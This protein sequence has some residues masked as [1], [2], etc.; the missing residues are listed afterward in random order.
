MIFKAARFSLAALAALFIV[1]APALAQ[2]QVPDHAVPIGRGAGTGFKSAVPGAAGGVLTSTGPIT[3]P[4]FS[5]AI[6]V[7]PELYGAIC[8]GNDANA[9]INTTALANMATAVRA[10][11]GGTVNFGINKVCSVMPSPAVGQST[12]MDFQS[13]C[14]G[15]RVNFNGSQLKFPATFTGGRTVI[16]IYLRNCYDVEINGFYAEQTTT[17]SSPDFNNGVMGIVVDDTNRDIRINGFYQKYG[18]STFEC[19]RNSELSVPNRTRGVVISSMTADQ[20]YYGATLQKNCDQTTIRALKT[21]NNARSMD[22]YNIHQLDFVLESEP[23]SS[24]AQDFLI[25]VLVNN[26]ESA[27][28]NTTSDVRGRYISRNQSGAAAGFGG[29]QIIQGTATPAAGTFRNIDLLFDIEVG[30]AAN[31]TIAWEL[32]KQ[33]N[34]GAADTTTR[35]HVVE[36]VRISGSLKGFANNIDLI[37][38]GST[39]TWAGETIRNIRF[40]DFAS[41]GSGTGAFVLDGTAHSSTVFDNARLAHNLTFTNDSGGIEFKANSTFTNNGTY[42]KLTNTSKPLVSAGQGSAPSYTTLSIAGGGTGA[43]TAAAARTALGSTTVGDA[44][45]IAANAAAGRS[46]LGAAEAGANTSITSL[47]GLTTPLSAAQGGTGIDLSASPTSYTPTLSSSLNTITTPG[48]TSGSSYSLGKL[49]YFTAQGTITVNGT[50]SG[51]VRFTLPFTATATATVV[52]ANASTGVEMI[53]RI[54][55]ATNYVELNRYDSVYPGADA[56]TLTVSGWF[57]K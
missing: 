1:C 9:A 33:L 40:E 36:N 34:T 47:G 16:A 46:A 48:A 25:S 10:A 12:L 41:T 11:G 38:W 13:G 55:A 15:L 57:V 14:E 53:G 27:S 19:R 28:S 35:G 3:D 20:T 45:F 54:A 56:T 17:L 18:R 2:W 37:R 30:T 7:T 50:G 44:V 32:F 51:S 21:V 8:D 29:S 23:G 31:T 4:A 52:G 26:A 42:A 5:P 43:V 22:A 24:T 39:G 6:T 49:V